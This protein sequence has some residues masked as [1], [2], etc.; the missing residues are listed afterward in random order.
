LTLT[1]PTDL[2]AMHCHYLERQQP[3]HRASGQ[4]AGHDAE[5]MCQSRISEGSTIV[6]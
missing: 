6:G 4:M 5:L 1:G 2:T 3:E